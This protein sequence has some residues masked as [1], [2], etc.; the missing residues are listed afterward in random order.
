VSGL[1]TWLAALRGLLIDLDGV[2][3]TG[4]QAIPGSAW[5]LGEARR[6]GFPFK[7]VTNNSARPPAA[8]A[9]RLRG[10]DIEVDP[11]EIVT[12]A[13]A[14]VAYITEESKPGARVL[15]I[16]EVGLHDA[17]AATGLTM[18]E[19]D[20]ADWVVVGLDRQF[21]YAKLAAATHA[22]HH[23]ARFV[24]TNADPLLPSEGGVMNPG[25]GCIVAAIQ[26]STVKPVVIGKPEPALFRR[27]LQRLGGFA[28]ADVAMIG[29]RLDT[30]V[31][32]ARNAGLRTI[33]VLS[34]G[35]TAVQLA[36]SELKPDA[37][38]DNL[39]GVAELLGWR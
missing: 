38:A 6:R 15:V 9:E 19:D 39:A 34:G 24:A 33:L 17:L 4:S 3:Y 8:V 29:D 18:V 5:F 36:A 30:D 20:S 2:V 14:A 26:T 12:S 11:N 37:S 25:A 21:T 10:M 1:S 23:G 13:E 16:G 27:G 32:G 31:A 7:L 35:T 22:I 28:P